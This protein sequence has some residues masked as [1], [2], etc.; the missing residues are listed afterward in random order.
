VATSPEGQYGRVQLPGLAA[1][2][3]YRIRVRTEPGLPSFHQVSGPAWLS[4][5]LDGR[6]TLPG[7]VLSV[8]GLPMP[9]LNPGQALLFELRRTDGA[10]PS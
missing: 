3:T 6:L 8:A 9:N 10:Q 4:A 7:S 5:A 1:E 2:G